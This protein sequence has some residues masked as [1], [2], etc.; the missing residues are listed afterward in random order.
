MN[1]DELNSIPDQMNEFIEVFKTDLGRS[2]RGHWCKLYTHT[3]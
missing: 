3:S 1:R 2:E